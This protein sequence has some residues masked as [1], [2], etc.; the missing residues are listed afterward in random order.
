[1]ISLRLVVI[2]IFIL[3]SRGISAQTYEYG[4][5][6]YATGY[7]GD[8]NTT[9]P[10]YYK[11]I[12]AGVFGQYNLTQT[13]GMRMNFIYLKLSA[14]DRDSNNSNQQKRNLEFHNQ[15]FELSL[16][17]VFNFFKFSP[18]S[19]GKQYSPYIM[20]GIGIVKHD[21]Y[22]YYLDSKIPLRQLQLERDKQDN[23][24]SYSALAF[25]IPL[26]LGFRFKAKRNWT[27][28]LET[29][30]RIVLSDNIDNI[31]GYYP[32]AIQEEVTSST[33]KVK[34]TEG[35]IRSLNSTDRLILTDPSGNFPNNKGSLR[36]NGKQW[37]GYMTTG[38][39]LSYTLRS[40][41]CVW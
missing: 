34:T 13:W 32:I 10:F 41:K 4:T 1:M 17:S 7:M 36:G 12:G 31:S 24:F 19:R 3:I 40:N 21:P 35:L 22:V 2:T 33:I 39:T 25:V 15:L 38:I 8:I 27:I 9:N 28:G 23:P 18:T 6:A 29:S 16:L 30:Y 11:N 5:T 14:Y 37:D 20:G 26:G